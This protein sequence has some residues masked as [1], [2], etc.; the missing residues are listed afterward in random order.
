MVGYMCSRAQLLFEGLGGL[1]NDDTGASV[2]TL[3]L[4]LKISWFRLVRTED[5]IFA[6]FP[7]RIGHVPNACLLDFTTSVW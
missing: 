4:T 6:L 2:W 3:I 7:G 5:F 1:K